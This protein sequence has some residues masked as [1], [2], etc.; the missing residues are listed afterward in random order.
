MLRMALPLALASWLDAMGV[1]DTS[2]RPAGSGG[3]RGR[4]PGRQPVLPIVIFGTGL[5]RDG[6]SGVAILRCQRPAGLPPQPGERSMARRRPGVPL[7]LVIW[8]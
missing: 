5:W 4:K 2:C 7:S 8:P 6:Y 1:V 3:H